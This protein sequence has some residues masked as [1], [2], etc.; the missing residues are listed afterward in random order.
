MCAAE[1]SNPSDNFLRFGLIAVAW[2]NTAS[3]AGVAF[4]ASLFT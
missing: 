2:R 1:G 4:F 3:A